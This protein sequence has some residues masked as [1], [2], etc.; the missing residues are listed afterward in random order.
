MVEVTTI[1]ILPSIC[2]VKRELE[3]CRLVLRKVYEQ[4]FDEARRIESLAGCQTAEILHHFTFTCVVFP[5]R[6]PL[7]IRVSFFLLLS[8]SPKPSSPLFL[9]RP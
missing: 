9:C 3:F 2:N 1:S 5:S 7:S 6:V 8:L 4:P